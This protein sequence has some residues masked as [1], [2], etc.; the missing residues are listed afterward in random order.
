M[1]GVARRMAP[2]RPGSKSPDLIFCEPEQSGRL[3]VQGL[4]SRLYVQ[5]GTG[6][7]GLRESVLDGGYTLLA[8][9][10]AILD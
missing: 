7:I 8:Q 5:R 3:V 6:T 4:A 1:S 2:A 9:Q 10:S